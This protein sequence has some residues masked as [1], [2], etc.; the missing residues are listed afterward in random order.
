MKKIKYVLLIL[1]FFT[2]IPNVFAEGENIVGN[3]VT[4][5]RDESNNYGVNKKWKITDKN[6]KNVLNTPLVD[7][8]K[9][10]YDFTGALTDEE[11]NKLREMITEFSNKYKT[12]IIIVTYNLPYTED[13]E[14]EEFAADF[15]DYNDFGLNYDKY[16]GILLFRNTYSMDPYYDM[17]TFGTAQLYFSHGDYDIILDGIYEELHSHSYLSGFSKFI[18]YVSTRYEGGQSPELR[19]YVIDENGFLKKLFYPAYTVIAVVS[20]IF[21]ACL[22]GHYIKKNKMVKKAVEASTYLN[23]DSVVYSVKNDVFLRKHLSSY[24]ISSSSGSGG[25]GYSSSGGSS[26]GGHSSGGGRH[27]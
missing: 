19:E 18:N 26:G 23:K 2:I 8:T 6:L 7:S 25:G 24:T 3:V 15:Y 12:E 14:N 20:G 4:Y 9:K 5:K 21:T 22:T 13:S 17:Y 16:D 1:L 10:I 11:E 27:G